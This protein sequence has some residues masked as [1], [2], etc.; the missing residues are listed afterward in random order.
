MK[1]IIIQLVLCVPINFKRLTRQ[2]IFI[3]EH[4]QTQ[5]ASKNKLINYIIIILTEMYIKAF[6][7]TTNERLFSHY[8]IIMHI[9]LL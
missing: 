1:Y 3:I 8:E 2:S 4:D 9:V 7:K 5:K 6:G